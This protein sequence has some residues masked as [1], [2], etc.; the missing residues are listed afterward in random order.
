M[1]I[2]KRRGARSHASEGG[3]YAASTVSR[4]D[5]QV[6]TVKKLLLELLDCAWAPRPCCG[7]PATGTY[8]ELPTSV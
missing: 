7:L 6:A 8:G 1:E 3:L 2:L 4:G 5:K